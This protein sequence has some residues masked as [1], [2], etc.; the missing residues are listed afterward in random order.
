MANS[1]RKVASFYQ[2]ERDEPVW[3]V[4]GRNY[5]AGDEE[6]SRSCALVAAICSTGEALA[7]SVS[8][9]ADLAYRGSATSCADAFLSCT[10]ATDAP[11]SAEAH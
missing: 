3:A 11:T 10:A 5:R 6:A 9:V 1:R 7:A 4:W 2:G 8:V